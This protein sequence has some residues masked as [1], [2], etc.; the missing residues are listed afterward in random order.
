MRICR[1]Q[2][3]QTTC[4]GCTDPALWLIGQRYDACGWVRHVPDIWFD[5]RVSRHQRDQA[6]VS[7]D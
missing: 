3:E 4:G 6:S 5:L 2:H 7:A 1:P